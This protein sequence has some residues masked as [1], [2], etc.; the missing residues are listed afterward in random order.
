[1]ATGAGKKIDVLDL[2]SGLGGF[3]SGF[4][5]SVFSVVRVDNCSMEGVDGQGVDYCMD[6]DDF[7]AQHSG[8]HF[9]VVLAGP[10]CAYCVVLYCI[11]LRL[12]RLVWVR[13]G[14]SWARH[15]MSNVNSR[16]DAASCVE[17]IQTEG[18]A[19]IKTVLR[20]VIQYRPRFWVL[21]NV[22]RAAPW[23]ANI[24]GVRHRVDEGGLLKAYKTKS[25]HP[26]AADRG[27]ASYAEAKDLAQRCMK[28]CGRPVMLH[29][30][31]GSGGRYFFGV[32]P[33]FAHRNAWTRKKMPNVARAGGYRRIK[34]VGNAATRSRVDFK[35][36]RAFAV[37]ISNSVHFNDFCSK[38]NKR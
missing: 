29:S 17:E 35:I 1:M 22:Q 8:K 6:C 30:G 7:L 4:D 23:L 19:G 26:T 25:V 24:L 18:L 14:T 21:E 12:L 27:H 5:A 2:Y 33:T 28:L 34:F 16:I 15:G 37:K 20:A 10:P 9:D 11:V 32:F 13:A 31:S 3:C 38:K 36:S